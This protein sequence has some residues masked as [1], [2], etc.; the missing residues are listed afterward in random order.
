M[1]RKSIFKLSLSLALLTQAYA[2][3]A[4]PP[5]PPQGQNQAQTPTGQGQMPPGAPQPKVV[6]TSDPTVQKA[7]QYAAGQMRG[8]A[9]GTILSAQT[10][11]KDNEIY[12]IKMQMS[13]GTVYQV[14]VC[15]PT[16]KP[17]KLQNKQKVQ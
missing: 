16:D 3:Q 11:G 1:G 13:N 8:G 14:E 9:V 17:W 4:L 12:V 10:Q 7:A 2:I 15:A 6:S 5:P